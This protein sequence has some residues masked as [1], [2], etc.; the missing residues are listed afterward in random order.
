MNTGMKIGSDL[1]DHIGSVP[2]ERDNKPWSKTFA[3]AFRAIKRAPAEVKFMGV[4]GAV[5][6]VGAGL[7]TLGF[8]AV[9]QN[10]LTAMPT[11][12]PTPTPTPSNATSYDYDVSEDVISPND[13]ATFEEPIDLN[14]SSL[15]RDLI[16]V[17]CSS[18][19]SAG[20]V[21]AARWC[22]HTILNLPNA[23]IEAGLVK[24]ADVLLIGY[25]K[26][27]V[28][29]DFKG[30]T[31]TPEMI[32]ACMDLFKYAIPRGVDIGE[33]Y[34]LIV[35]VCDAV[36]KRL[37]STMAG[38][39]ILNEM[40]IWLDRNYSTS[41]KK[42]RCLVG[43]D[44]PTTPMLW[45][46]GIPTVVCDD[47]ASDYAEIIDMPPQSAIPEIPTKKEEE[48]PTSLYISRRV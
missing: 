38:N 30:A 11:A 20:A 39:Y 43:L 2:K 42:Y 24:G 28:A 9:N 26:K 3:E 25:G 34:D 6:L 19:A 31:H 14:C 29:I 37:N 46:R 23:R 48:R 40:Q 5:C 1:V 10:G 22:Y 32:D 12:L 17:V 36:D 47:D 18:L 27:S 45:T 16:I 33:V 7:S 21:G 41:F 8:M 35:D 13:S 4:L 44:S 15:L